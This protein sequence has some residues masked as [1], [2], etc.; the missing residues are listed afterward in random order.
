MKGE[1]S[2]FVLVAVLVLGFADVLAQAPP[3]PAPPS[4]EQQSLVTQLHAIGCQAEENAAAQ[5]IDQLR[6]ENASLR[7]EVQKA[8]PPKSGATKH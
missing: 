8:D 6:K 1:Y 7:A 3:A 2:L 5:T 4:A